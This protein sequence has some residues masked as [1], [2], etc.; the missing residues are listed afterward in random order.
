MLSWSGQP[1]PASLTKVELLPNPQTNAL[2]LKKVSKQ[3]WQCVQGYMG[4][5]NF[6]YPAMLAQE[7]IKEALE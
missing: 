6:S 3:L 5:I 7:I 2:L 4:D 1:L